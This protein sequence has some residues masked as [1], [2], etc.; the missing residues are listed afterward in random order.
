MLGA[1][2]ISDFGCLQILEYYIHTVLASLI[3][4]SEI[5]NASVRFPLSIMLVLKK[6]QILE[7]FG[8]QIF[9]LGILS[10][11]QLHK[12]NGEVLPR[13]CFLEEIVY[14]FC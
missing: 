4:N 3:Q 13:L 11:F 5:W 2:N 7:H 1:R 8:V 12:M 10:L 9:R 14:N 6:F